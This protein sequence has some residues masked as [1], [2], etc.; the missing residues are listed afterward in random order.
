MRWARPENLIA[1]CA[2]ASA[3]DG[4]YSFAGLP[5][6]SHDGGVVRR[7]EFITIL[8]GAAIVWSRDCLAQT[9]TKV[10]RLGSL[11]PARPL[12][13]TSPDPARQCWLFSPCTL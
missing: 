5:G 4:S 10:Y 11:D 12:S 8:G 13:A 3:G 9:S 7:R 2:F 6:T 1:Y